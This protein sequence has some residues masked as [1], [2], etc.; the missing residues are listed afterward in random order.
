[1]VHD[2]R[3]ERLHLPIIPCRDVIQRRLAEI[4]KLA[5]KLEILLTTADQMDAVDSSP[6][7][8]EQAAENSTSGVD[9]P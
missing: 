2:L 6:V 4:R 5:A 3:A 7:L 1:M 9:R 8:M